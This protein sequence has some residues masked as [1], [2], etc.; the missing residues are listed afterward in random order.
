[1]R[2]DKAGLPLE[3]ILT[4]SATEYFAMVGKDPQDYTPVGV[5]HC[6]TAW[7]EG[8]SLSDIDLPASIQKRVPLGTEVV[9]AYR[10]Q[11]QGDAKSCIY[12]VEGTAL[13]PKKRD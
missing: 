8:S 9:V 4:I 10:S 13:V 1:M 11:L 12:S 5:H 7:T 3:R 6:S 2:Q